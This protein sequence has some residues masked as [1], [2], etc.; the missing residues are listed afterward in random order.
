MPHVV[1][2]RC[3]DCRY[4]DCCAVCPVECFWEVEKPAMLVID[5]KTCIDCGL[6]IP[7][8]PIY[9]IYP[10]EEVPEAYKE[11][12]QKNAD[13]FPKGKHCTAKKDALPTAISLDKIHEKEKAKGWKI[14][15]PTAVGGGGGGGGASKPKP[16]AAPAAAKKPAEVAAAA[17]EAPPGYHPKPLNLPK[18]PKKPPLGVNPGGR[19]RLGYRKGVVQELRQGL[20]KEYYSDVKILFDGDAKP[21]WFGYLSLQV[22]KEKGDFEVLDAGPKPNFFKRLLGG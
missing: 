8:C 6:C 21:I 17:E 18:A 16:A 22:F 19:I 20:G 10:L 4:T 2:D 14:P 12:I 13:L 15:D 3:V 5:P 1:T 9:A 11:W 7:E